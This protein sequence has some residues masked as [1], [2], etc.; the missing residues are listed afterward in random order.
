MLRPN[1]AWSGA[2]SQ[3]RGAALTRAT[4][5]LAAAVGVVGGIYGIGGGSL[6]GPILV[7]RGTPVATVAPAALASTFVT[8][9][10]GAATLALLSLTAT[11]DVAPDWPTG[12][13]CGLGGLAGG[14]LGAALQPRLPETPCATCWAPSPQGSACSTPSKACAENA[15]TEAPPNLT[16]I[17]TLTPG[18]IASRTDVEV[19]PELMDEAK[20]TTVS[21]PA[22]VDGIPAST[23]SMPTGVRVPLHVRGLRHP[24]PASP[25]ARRT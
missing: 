3:H 16:A 18:L 9:V 2:R 20:V 19:P 13:A 4:G 12:L 14:Y 22:A 21:G 1:P 7:G 11:G 15:R 8:S 17:P 5:R 23:A 24:M 25:P 10:V 6:L